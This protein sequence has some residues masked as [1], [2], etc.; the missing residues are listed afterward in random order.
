MYSG[1][2]FFTREQIESLRDACDW[3][4]KPPTSEL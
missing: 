1:K 4:E 2:R 3:P